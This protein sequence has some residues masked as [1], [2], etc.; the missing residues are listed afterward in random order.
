[1]EFKL[2]TLTPI[3]TG[4]VKR[5][6]NTIIHLTG[7]KGGIR[8]WYETLIRG[9]DHYACDPT[10]N[11]KSCKIET[12]ALDLSSSP[13]L[14]VKKFICPACYL[15]GCTGWSGKFIL[16][17]TVQSTDKQ[18]NSLSSCG[19]PFKLHFIERKTFEKAEE[20]LLTMTLKLIV[21]YGAIGGKTVLKPSEKDFKNSENYGGGRHRDYGIFDVFRDKNGNNISGISPSTIYSGEVKNEVDVYLNAFDKPMLKNERDWPNLKNFWFVKDDCIRR[22][23]HNKIVSRDNNGKYFNAPSELAVFS[24]GFIS[25]EKDKFSKLDAYKTVNAASKKIFSFHGIKPDAVIKDNETL[26][27]SD[28]RVIQGI[29]RCFGYAKKDMLDAIIKL[30][31]DNSK[32]KGKIKKGMEVLNEL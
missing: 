23:E 29:R 26:L 30:I 4:G 9:L 31:E 7:F 25:R 21:N 28:G 20:Y 16:R 24:G 13:L 11:D 14:Q 18:I 6:D 1:M 2:K 17:L 32:L 10:S 15:F 19:I 3:W 8:W 27:P 5:N 12:K 22:D